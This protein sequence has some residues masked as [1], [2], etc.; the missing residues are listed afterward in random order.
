[1]RC[2][3]SGMVRYSLSEGRVLRLPVAMDAATN[4]AAHLEWE[5]KK[6]EKQSKKERMLVRVGQ[7]GGRRLVFG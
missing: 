2:V 5:K 7:S 4:L 3:K 1:M 6:A